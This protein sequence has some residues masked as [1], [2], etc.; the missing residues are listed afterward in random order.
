VV[1][2]KVVIFYFFFYYF[3]HLLGLCLYKLIWF[4]MI[5]MSGAMVYF[6]TRILRIEK[7]MNIFLT[8][9]N[10]W[11]YNIIRLKQLFNKDLIFN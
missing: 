9:F 11:L 7:G 3:F 2:L 6:Y 1:L 4:M 5:V 10:I 8:I